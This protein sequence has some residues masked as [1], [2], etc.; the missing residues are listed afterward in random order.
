MTLGTISLLLPLAAGYPAAPVTA[1]PGCG[2]GGCPPAVYAGGPGCPP[3]ACLSPRV[4][5]PDLCVPTGPPAP[6][7]AAKIIAPPGVRVTLQPGTPLAKVFPAPVPVGFRPGYSYRI[8]LAGLPGRPG[9]VLYPEIEVRGSLVPRPGMNYMD[10][11]AAIVFSATDIERAATG[12]LVTKVVFLEDPDRAVPVR[13]TP[14][15]PVESPAPSEEDAIRTALDNGRLVMIVRLGNRVPD[16]TTLCE[17]AVPGTVLFPGDRHLAAPA[18]PPRLPFC[19]IPLFDP[20]LGPKFPAEECLPDGGDV[21]PRLGIGPDGR[22]YGL[23]PTDVSA[24]YTQAGMRRVTT[25]NRVCVCVPRFA[26]ERVEVGP[27]GLRLALRPEAGV[28]ASNTAVLLSRLPVQSV[29]TRY[30]PTGF[31]SL[32]RPQAQVG[33]EG[34]MALIEYTRPRAFAN[35]AGVRIMATAVGPEEATNFDGFVVTKTIDPA[36]GVKIGDEVTVTI[37]YVNNSRLAVSEVVVSDNLTARLEYV[38]GS[39]ESDRPANVTTELNEVGSS[40]VRFDIPGAV[41]PGQGG[42]VRFRARVR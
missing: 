12:S 42:V 26:V 35:R 2:P 24:E 8:E 36:T 22:L 15:R 37:R 23:N 32:L 7:L 30:K 5:P 33:V 25:S 16:E 18:V 9:T 6:V 10:Y 4:G 39:G 38:P 20:I 3:T 28:Q 31:V 40:I 19:G 21:G 14:D 13:T 27:G 1:G 11:P 17:S 29:F 34:I 41:Q